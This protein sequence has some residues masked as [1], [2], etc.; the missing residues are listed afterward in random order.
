MPATSF[1]RH[2]TSIIKWSR[3]T[4]AWKLICF[5]WITEKI[6]RIG[7]HHWQFEA[8]QFEFL[9]FMDTSDQTWK[10]TEIQV[11]KFGYFLHYT[12]NFLIGRGSQIKKGDLC[13]EGEQQITGFPVSL[14]LH[15]MIS[16]YD[17]SSFFPSCFCMEAPRRHKMECYNL[18][19][20]APP[21]YNHFSNRDT[22]FHVMTPYWFQATPQW[23]INHWLS[24]V[25]FKNTDQLWL[26][27]NRHKDQ[28]CNC[29][30]GVSGE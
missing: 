14:A 3:A 12:N 2:S 15:K 22:E 19:L 20:V 25:K 4:D 16:Q 28:A 6:I 9:E 7:S 13:A 18:H 24:S 11:M 30:Q 29:A 21:A 1:S 23:G 27:Q 10:W 17:Q 8:L 26:W 5:I